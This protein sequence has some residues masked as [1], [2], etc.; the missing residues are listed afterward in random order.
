MCHT[1]Q[2]IN[3]DTG[4]TQDMNVLIHK[5]HMGENLPSVKAGTPYRIWHRGAWSDFSEVKFPSGSDQLKSCTVCHQKATQADNYF[6]APSRAACG[7]CHDDVNFAT[8]LNH[9]NLPQVS[10]NQCAECHIPQGDLEFDASIKGAHTV[11]NRST[12]LPG[13]VTQ[14]QKVVNTGAG[15]TPSVTFKVTDKAGNAVDISKL[16]SIRVVLSG[17]NNDYGYGPT[18]IRVSED[19]SKTAGSGGVYTYTT[20][21]KIPAGAKGSYTISI[22]ARNSV[23]LLAGTVKQTTGIDAAKPTQFYFSVD[24]SKVAA[25]RQVVS[26]DKCAACHVDLTFVHS[27]T[28]ADTQ[29]CAICHNPTL[30]DSS[31]A[32]VSF[33][34]QIHSIHRGDALVNPY[35]IGGRNYQDVG[36]PGDLRDCA[37]CHVNGSYNP[38]VVPAAAPIATPGALITPTTPPIT[39]ACQGCHDDK[40]TA[41]HAADNTSQFGES[42]AVCHGS[43][44]A[45]A[46]DKV[47]SR[48]Q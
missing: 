41:S 4:L 16:A 26:N 13:L 35:V 30:T 12:S 14:I 15:Q 8:G 29:E 3:P 36:F 22:E 27:A 20:T 1:P 18:G 31:K 38:D 11:A 21:N 24:G 28:R 10:D 48:V 37:V 42:C 6:K 46:V 7:S 32:S 5:I 25:R 45:F 33:A 40:A 34:S 44:S 17:P 19:P 39:A 47:H 2:T 43:S 23:I 9:V